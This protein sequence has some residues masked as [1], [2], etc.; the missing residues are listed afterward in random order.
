MTMAALGIGKAL[1]SRYLEALALLPE[2]LKN[3]RQLAVNGL[4]FGRELRITLLERI[5]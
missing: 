5:E 4:G 1:N 3:A 2:A